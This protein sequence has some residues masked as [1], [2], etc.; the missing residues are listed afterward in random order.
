MVAEDMSCVRE[1]HGR[2]LACFFLQ[3]PRQA[4]NVDEKKFASPGGSV[5]PGTQCNRS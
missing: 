2:Q 5:R 1:L 3:G 4:E